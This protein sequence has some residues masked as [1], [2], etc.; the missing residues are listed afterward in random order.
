ML[1]PGRLFPLCVLLQVR[2]EQQV[3]RAG[4]DRLWRTISDLQVGLD[5]L[6]S[7]QGAM[8]LRMSQIFHR[9]SG[10]ADLR[11]AEP[12]LRTLRVRSTPSL[13]VLLTTQHFT[14]CCNVQRTS[15]KIQVWKDAKDAKDA[16]D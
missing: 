10:L 14:L 7:E 6:K 13:T 2:K 8:S 11:S 9:A 3:Q 4:G 15:L 5:E 1:Q 16:K 12:S